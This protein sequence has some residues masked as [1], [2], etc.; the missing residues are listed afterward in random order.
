MRGYAFIEF[1]READM[2]AAYK[3]GDGQLV[4][5]GAALRR[6]LDSSA[7]SHQRRGDVD[8]AKA[9]KHFPYPMAVVRWDATGVIA[10]YPMG[11]KGRF[12]I[13]LKQDEPLSPRS[14]ARLGRMA[15]PIAGVKE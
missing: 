7:T 1:E 15:A 13:M 4:A 6:H 14:R 3:R 2:R 12:A 8:M 5:N 10:A 9:L 11:H